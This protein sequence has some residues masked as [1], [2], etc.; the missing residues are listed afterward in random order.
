MKKG[1]TRR[2]RR[3]RDV[4]TMEDVARHA[5]VSA[6]TVSRV[7]NNEPNV[8]DATREAVEASIE[9]LGY[10][11]NE[12]ARALAGAKHVQIAFVYHEPS[13]YVAEFLFGS[14]D[15][16]RARNASFVVEKCADI[17][18]AEETLRRLIAAG[19]D[20]VLLQPP[21][22]D[23]R[24][25]LDIL[26]KAGMPAVVITARAARDSVSAVSID[27]FDAAYQ[28]TMFLVD[29]GHRKIGFITG[30]PEQL[31]SERRLEGHR[32]ALRDAGIGPEGERIVEG[33]FN[34]RSGIEAAAKLLDADDP[35]TAIFASNDEMAIATIAVAHSRSLDVP[36]DLSVVGF[37]DVPMAKSVWPA[38]TTIRQP[39]ADMGGAAADLLVEEILS[40]R[41]GEQPPAQHLLL[42]YQLVERES[43]AE[44]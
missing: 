20:G 8:S 23:S 24:R 1:S 26:E 2:S 37:D 30:N 25:L 15:Q 13:A 12:S 40:R 43:V 34:F 7:I 3:R 35:P 4:L 39:V 41:A 36:R 9:E 27:D 11:P 14:F 19:V 28:M 17:S 29:H 32:A 44:I 10:Q 21:F 42:D 6:M 16:L 38:L 5:G 31:A 33:D 22:S 18:I